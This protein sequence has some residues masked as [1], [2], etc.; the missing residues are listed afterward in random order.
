MNRKRNRVR[1]GLGIASSEVRFRSVF[2]VVF[3]LTFSAM[4]GCSLTKSEKG[5][6]FDPN[7]PVED[8]GLQR[9]TEQLIV[10]MDN[11]EYLRPNKRDGEDRVICFAGVQNLNGEELPGISEAIRRQIEK[12]TPYRFLSDAEIERALEKS[13]VKK[14][15]ILIPEDRE[16]FVRAVDRPFQYLLTA[17]VVNAPEAEMSQGDLGGD[18]IV[19]NLVSLDNEEDKAI[20]QSRLASVYNESRKRGIF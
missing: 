16:K 18:Q 19:F 1:S 12:T 10:K 8:Y 9:A 14:N 6:A 13:K 4:V 20:I 5:P 17:Q 7:V 2:L 15:D 11:I 3:L